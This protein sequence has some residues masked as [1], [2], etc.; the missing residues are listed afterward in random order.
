MDYT[1]LI[2]R[3]D[4]FNILQDD[5][6][7][8]RPAHAY[9]LICADKVYLRSY[10]KLFAQSILTFNSLADVDR[11]AKLVQEENYADLKIYPK[12]VG[13]RLKVDDMVELIEESNLLPTEG[14]KKVFIIDASVDFSQICQNK[15]LKTL[16][17]PPENVTLLIGCLSEYSILPTG[18]SRVKKLRIGAFNNE[19]I[20]YAMRNFDDKERLALAIKNCD[21]SLGMAERLYGD[22]RL[23]E[24]ESLAES[25]AIKMKKSP[26]V[27][28]F[29]NKAVELKGDFGDFLGILKGKIYSLKDR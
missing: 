21:G 3:V 5:F 20:S 17:E 28:H 13:E 23:V 24:L 27:L 7:G 16:E 8:G 22:K 12:V 2:Q 19:Q 9:M 10:L 1:P 6:K 11:I 15:I 29:S 14:D 4:A 25:V 18:L 26:E